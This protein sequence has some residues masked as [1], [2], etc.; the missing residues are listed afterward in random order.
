MEE[1]LEK[2]VTCRHWIPTN[3]FIPINEE[4]KRLLEYKQNGDEVLYKIQYDF[5]SKF[6]GRCRRYPPQIIPTTGES[7][8]PNTTAFFGCGEYKT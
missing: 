1:L 6:H 8:L 3:R 5:V 4:V 2:C 7:I